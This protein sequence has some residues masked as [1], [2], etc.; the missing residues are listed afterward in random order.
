MKE[1]L[2]LMTFSFLSSNLFSDTSYASIGIAVNKFQYFG[3][4]H[5]F[6]SLLEYNYNSNNITSLGVSNFFSNTINL[7]QNE[8]N[9]TLIDGFSSYTHFKFGVFFRDVSSSKLTVN[10]RVLL[11]ICFSFAKKNFNKFALEDNFSAS[12]SEKIPKDSDVFLGKWNKFPSSDIL[13][14]FCFRFPVG[15]SISTFGKDLIKDSMF[16]GSGISMGV[17]L[18]SFLESIIVSNMNFFMSNNNTPSNLDFNDYIFKQKDIS[19]LVFSDSRSFNIW[20][21][22]FSAIGIK[23]SKALSVGISMNLYLQTNFNYKESEASINFSGDEVDIKI[24]DSSKS[25]KSQYYNVI[26][27]SDVVN[28]VKNKSKFLFDGKTI[29]IINFSISMFCCFYKK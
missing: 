15:L 19:P 17:F 5:C 28:S 22:L 18:K 2:I 29:E 7:F 26:V 9:N 25:K 12:I 20:A 4:T 23:V 27:F 24:E 3:Y 21:T 14:V 1:K 13:S 11:G 10:I 6:S 8:D 16:V